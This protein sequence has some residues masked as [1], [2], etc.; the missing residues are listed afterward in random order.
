MEN[1]AGEGI[2]REIDLLAKVHYTDIPLRHLRLDLHFRQIVGDHE[3]GRCVQARRHRLPHVHAAHNDNSINGRANGA[4]R[5]IN[6]GL[7]EIS[8]ADLCEGRG[9][10]DIRARFV[11]VRLGNEILGTERLC[12]RFLDAYAPTA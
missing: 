2:H 9:L 3:K 8:L 7:R 5:Q 6:L 11:K 4:A 10:V 12:A 1:L